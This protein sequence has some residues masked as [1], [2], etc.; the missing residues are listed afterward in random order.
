MGKAYGDTAP[1]SAADPP[2]GG[3]MAVGQCETVETP[4]RSVGGNGSPWCHLVSQ[5]TIKVMGWDDTT[6]GFACQWAVPKFPPTLIER[7]PHDPSTRQLTDSGQVSS[8]P[9]RGRECCFMNSS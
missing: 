7:S 6:D 2:V 8:L 9:R 3:L 5:P 4:D 1:T